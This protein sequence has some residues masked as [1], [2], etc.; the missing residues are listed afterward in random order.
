MVRDSNRS[1]HDRVAGKYDQIYETPY[2]RFYR[3][4]SW[5][6]LK[7]FLP[8]PRPARAADFGCGTGWF[9]V[10][11]L[12]A[13]FDVEFVDPSAKMLDQ[14]RRNAEPEARRGV[15]AG[16]VLAGLEDLAGLGDASLDF[17]TAQG[18]P[19]SFCEDPA[20]ALAELARV[21]KAGGALVL[22]VDSRVAGVRSLAGGEQPAEMLELLRTGRT[23]WRGERAAERF[24]M[25]MFDPDELHAL[26]ARAGFEV[27]STIA[28]TCLV[29]RE[30][31][32]WLAAPAVHRELLAA[33]ERVHG[34]PHWFALAAHFQVAARRR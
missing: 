34:L 32:A 10:R 6:H 26:L 14:A 33:E 30:H 18:D 27:E 9:G 31:D 24:P 2:W 13:G 3:E 23:R 15:T 25:K 28:K 1:Y 29:Q 12:T 11:L 17:S 21:T 8:A 19:L 20:R 4:V 5:R 22:S 16:F 7:R